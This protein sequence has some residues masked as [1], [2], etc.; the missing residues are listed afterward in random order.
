MNS[1][2]TRGQG[3]DVRG[4][5]WASRSFLTALVIFILLFSL[6]FQLQH[7]QTLIRNSFDQWAIIGHLHFHNT[8]ANVIFYIFFPLC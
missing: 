2:L 8:I 3:L 4:L 1:E 7:N 5:T 6:I